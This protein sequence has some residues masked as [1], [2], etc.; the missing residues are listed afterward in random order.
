MSEKTLK[1]EYANSKDAVYEIGTSNSK[2]IFK[3]IDYLNDALSNLSGISGF[4]LGSVTKPIEDVKDALEYDR[5][6]YVSF[7]PYLEQFYQD[8]ENADELLKCQITKLFSDNITDDSHFHKLVDNYYADYVAV[9]ISQAAESLNK[10]HVTVSA[11]DL[12]AMAQLY[13]LEEQIREKQKKGESTDELGK[14]MREILQEK[15]GNPTAAGFTISDTGKTILEE[16]IA[17]KYPRLSKSD[18]LELQSQIDSLTRQLSRQNLSYIKPG[19]QSEKILQNILGKLD[20]EKETIKISEEGIEYSDE[21]DHVGRGLVALQLGMDG[22]QDIVVDGRNWDY[23]LKDI[24]ADG[25]G[26]GASAAAGAG[27]GA[28]FGGLAGTIIGA[29]VGTGADFA[30]NIN[31]KEH[32]QNKLEEGQDWWEECQW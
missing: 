9:S 31:L 25:I 24:A 4:S 23:A 14:A 8:V 1:V 2:H 10:S 11:D 18:T 20:N 3:I 28:P 5:R 15:L 30:Y 21:L 7:A 6:R 19:S 16:Y 26:I 27:A 13:S 22:Y 32:V 12:S 29:I 17:M